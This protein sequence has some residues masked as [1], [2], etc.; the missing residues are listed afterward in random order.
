MFALYV[1]VILLT[2]FSNVFSAV[3]DFVRY[4][5]GDCKIF[6]VNVLRCR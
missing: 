6:C 5:Q 2:V 4:E 1:A 3:C